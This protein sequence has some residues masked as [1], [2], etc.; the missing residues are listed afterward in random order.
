MFVKWG[1]DEEEEKHG[2]SLE[3]MWRKVSIL[4]KL[5]LALMVLLREEGKVQLL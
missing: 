2:K 1:D 4:K 5:M 3:K